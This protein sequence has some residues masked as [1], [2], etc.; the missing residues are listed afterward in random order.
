MIEEK[1]LLYG[2]KI[3]ELQRINT[4]SLSTLFV[5]SQDTDA[6]YI[7]VATDFKTISD[8][9]KTSVIRS[10]NLGTAAFYSVGT[11]ENQI[12]LLS[13]DGKIPFSM[14]P[15]ITIP[16]G[17]KG[18]TG[19][20]YV[21][22]IS[23]DGYLTWE[24]KQIP[25]P[26]PNIPAFYIKGEQGPEGKQG[27]PGLPGAVGPSYYYTPI[28][29]LNGDL[30]WEPSDP[31]LPPINV[32]NIKGNIGSTGKKGD[33]GS[34]GY[35]YIPSVTATGILTWTI[36]DSYTEDNVPPSL[37]AVNIRGPYYIPY[38]DSD[39]NLTWLAQA[40]GMAPV[41]DRVN[42]KG[43]KGDTG[44]VGPYYIPV[45]TNGS[46]TFKGSEGSLL[47]EIVVG[48][49]VGPQGPTGLTGSTGKAFFPDAIGDASYLGNYNNT[50]SGFI[51]LAKDTGFAYFK[52]SD[53][54]S[55]DSW[56]PAQWAGP[57]LQGNYI[58][59][60]LSQASTKRQL[61]LDNAT[62]PVAIEIVDKG[63]YFMIDP[64]WI[65]KTDASFIIDVDPFLAA[66]N[67]SDPSGTYRVWRAGGRQGYYY[68]PS[69]D[70]NGTLTWTPSDPE[71]SLPYVASVNIRGPQGIQG[72]IGPQGIQ[73][74]RGGTFAVSVTTSVP[75]NM[76]S[77][78]IYFILE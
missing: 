56:E 25:F 34:S 52:V 8:T 38:I 30:S 28:V 73:G 67:L 75:E 43:P 18:D 10:L 44:P 78:T 61:V 51:Y 39:Y 17:A 23:S 20:T 7:T 62:I 31:S 54:P 35:T 76:D 71:V 60:Q 14:L 53:E 70:V 77:T 24:A 47:N 40:E 48:N 22:S 1:D 49:I 15:P 46:L 50:S 63:I 65:H 72:P 29:A 6:G 13:K 32:V 9:V 41:D 21:P 64:S 57:P 37:P 4:I 74:E 58:D 19:P 42:I 33:R 12:P 69:V 59:V 11:K 26:Y 2:L 3:S 27:P 66:A 45:V 55:I 5:V 16:S 36:S 68:I